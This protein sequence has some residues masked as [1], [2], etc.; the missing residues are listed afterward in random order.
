M[1]LN[2]RD[3]QEHVN[4]GHGLRWRCKFWSFIR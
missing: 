2:M 1:K 4:M 3:I